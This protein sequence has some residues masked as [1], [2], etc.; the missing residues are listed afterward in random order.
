ML[1][2][3][4]PADFRPKLP[5]FRVATRPRVVLS[6]SYGKRLKTKFPKLPDYHLQRR[7]TI[8]SSLK[9]YQLIATFK[10][11]YVLASVGLCSVGKI[12]TI[13]HFSDGYV[14]NN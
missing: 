4:N 9:K 14:L 11:G 7:I 2:D 3:F 12:V 8:H 10:V 6:P 1:V 13:Q 5:T